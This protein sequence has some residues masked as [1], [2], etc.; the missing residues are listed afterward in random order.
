MSTRKIS[1]CISIRIN[2]GNYQHIE[3]T[4]YAEEEIEYNSDKER[5]IHED[6]LRNDLLSGL[7]KSMH[8]V[9]KRLGK[10]VEEA[11]EVEEAI[12]KAIPEWLKN[13]PVPNIA[14]Q[15]SQ[16]NLKNAAEQKNNKDSNAKNTSDVIIENE[17]TNNSDI[18]SDK[19]ETIDE[20]LFNDEPKH[21]NEVQK[22]MPESNSKDNNDLESLFDDDDD[23][24]DDLFGDN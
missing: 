12:V 14:N 5:E 19:L 18:K 20:D 16:N 4:K 15:A 11:Q 13:N 24:D 8:E 2:V 17:S 10:G 7:I 22:Q 9:P 3:L 1:E 6:A 23:D 21:N